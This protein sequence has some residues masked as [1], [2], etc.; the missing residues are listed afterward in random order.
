MSNESYSGKRGNPVVGLLQSRIVTDPFSHEGPK[1][2][3]FDDGRGPK[4]WRLGNVETAG[5]VV[6]VKLGCRVC[7]LGCCWVC[8]SWW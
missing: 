8:R 7:P 5:V 2:E 4:P 6:G 1:I 3:I